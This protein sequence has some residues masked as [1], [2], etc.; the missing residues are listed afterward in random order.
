MQELGLIAADGAKATTAKP[1]PTKNILVVD[2]NMINRQ[3]LESFLIALGMQ[4]ETVSSGPAAI[5]RVEQGS[6]DIVMMDVQMPGMDGYETTRVLRDK[7]FALP[8][9]ACTAHAFESDRE[10]AM[11]CG[12]NGHLLKP[13]DKEALRSLIQSMVDNSLKRAS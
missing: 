13:V 5:E 3:V 11:E 12:M 10:R 6:F 1:L 4:V 9:V 7:G 2:D 8:I